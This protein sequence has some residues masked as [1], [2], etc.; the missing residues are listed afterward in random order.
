MFLRGAKEVKINGIEL[1]LVHISFNEKQVKPK[2]L[3]QGNISV[4]NP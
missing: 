4:L 3:A 2:L 1:I